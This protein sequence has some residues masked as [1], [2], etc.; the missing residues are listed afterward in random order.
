M[1]VYHLGS[2]K[3]YEVVGTV[4]IDGITNFVL[5]NSDNLFMTSPICNF[6]KF[7]QEEYRRRYEQEHRKEYMVNI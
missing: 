5:A 7:N 3:I 1:K 2:K 6:K 4:V